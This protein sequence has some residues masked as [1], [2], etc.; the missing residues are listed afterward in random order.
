M[1]K[2]ADFDTISI[3]IIFYIHV[4]MYYV[5]GWWLLSRGGGKWPPAPLNETLF[6]KIRRNT[7]KIFI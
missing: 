4:Y 3:Q 2:T 6:I 7:L 1:S 5:Y